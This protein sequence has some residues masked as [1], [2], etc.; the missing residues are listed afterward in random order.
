MA[1]A[2]GW[3]M[4]QTIFWMAMAKTSGD[5]PRPSLMGAAKRPKLVLKPYVIRAIRHPHR[6][7]KAGA[8][9]Q[10]SFSVPK[11]LHPSLDPGRRHQT[12]LFG[13]TG[14]IRCGVRC[15]GH[16]VQSAVSIIG[17]SGRLRRGLHTTAGDPVLGK[18]SEIIVQ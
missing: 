10:P 3:P 2:N 7:T 17:G 9:H 4:P 14:Q 1:P 5:Q 18:T 16:G 13:T 8:R 12:T 11:T 15:S 6:T